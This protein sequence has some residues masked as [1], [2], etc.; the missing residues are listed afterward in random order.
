MSLKDQ[1]SS[2]RGVPFAVS[3]AVFLGLTPIFGKQALNAGML[4]LA[5]VAART[6]GAAGLLFLVVLT[7]RR[8]YLYIFPLG[9]VGC[10]IAGGLNGI[11]S[12]LFYSALAR[13]DAGL[14]QLLFGLYPI[15]VA[16][17]LYLDGQRH[18]RGTLLSLAL[19]LP[20]V[21]LLTQASA[22]HIDPVGIGLM[23]CAGLLYALHIPINQRVLYEAPAPTVTLYT[24]VAMTVVV[25]PAHL[26]FS[27]SLMG[28][29]QAALPPLAW[30]TAV[31]FL[32]RLTLFAG[33]KSIGGM[34]TSLL[35]LVEVLVTVGLANI[36]LG[37][38]LSP[39][40]WLGAILLGF[41]LILTGRDRTRTTIPRRSGWLQWL[42]PPISPPTPPPVKFPDPASDETAWQN[43]ERDEGSGNKPR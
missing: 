19:S 7:F 40:Q 17:L 30:L 32:S 21:Y 34:R 18:T 20:A 33:V 24:L 15:F 39:T 14:G 29:P 2:N 35:G 28:F 5:V 10:F 3:S 26:I 38:S 6:A 27:P 1:V 25:V 36:L 43:P 31:T 8:R 16:V 13:I 11:G 41:A 12:L 9:L 23:L 42:R 22:S 4:P 37:E